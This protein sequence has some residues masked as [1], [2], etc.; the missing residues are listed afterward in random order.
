MGTSF[1]RTDFWD[2]FRGQVLRLFKGVLRHSLTNHCLHTISSIFYLFLHHTVISSKQ[3]KVSPPPLFNVVAVWIPTCMI[4][5]KR[6][7]ENPHSFGDG[8][9]FSQDDTKNRYFCNMCQVMTEGCSFVF[10]FHTRSSCYFSCHILRLW[11]CL[12]RCSTKKWIHG[13]GPQ[14]FWGHSNSYGWTTRVF[15]PRLEPILKACCTYPQQRHMKI[16]W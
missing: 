6:L 5:D 14:N 8:L 10:K 15:C 16:R 2:C 1:R 13:L 12:C 11:P 3:N 7:G 9:R 4:L